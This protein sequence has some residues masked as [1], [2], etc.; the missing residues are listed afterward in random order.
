MN[1][2]SLRERVGVRV[3]RLKPTIF[4][5]LLILLAT[6]GA[7]DSAATPTPTA[8]PPTA[9]PIPPAATVA[10]TDPPAATASPPTPTA[11]P[12]PTV[13]ATPA[14]GSPTD[15]PKPDVVAIP[16]DHPAVPFSLL[17]GDSRVAMYLD[18]ETVSQRP[19][20]SE[21]IEFQLWNFFSNRDLPLAEEML[22]SADVRALSLSFL[23][24]SGNWACILNGNFV[25]VED[26]LQLTAEPGAGLSMTERE[27]HREVA[28]FTVAPGIGPASGALPEIYV[29]IPSSDTL[30]ASPSLSA[31]REMVERRVDG[32]NL[33]EPLAVMLEDWGLA[34]YNLVASLEELNGDSWD[35]PTVPARYYALHA[36]LSEE[37]TTIMRAL[38]QYDNDEQ[39][40]ASVAWRNEQTEPYFRKIGWAGTVS[41]DEWRH[42]GAT[43]YAEATVPD[44]D[45]PAIVQGK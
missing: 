5:C 43:E 18:I 24:P 29:A 10:P 32:G 36:T 6:I 20:L 21:A 11:A 35:R 26:T 37:S 23:H 12:P 44:A 38:R 4:L 17:P 28:I 40:A 1:P 22:N 13:A 33:P 34:D 27:P 41:I 14:E 2:L 3:G 31:V 8:Q 16:S 19:A 9:T 25:Q 39:A 30:V 15:R 45:I 42:K 7:C